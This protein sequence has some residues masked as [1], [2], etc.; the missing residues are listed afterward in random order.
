MKNNEPVAEEKE[1]IIHLLKVLSQ[2]ND[3][4]HAIDDNNNFRQEIAHFEETFKTVRWKTR[5]FLT[6]FG[7]C[8]TD[9]YMAYCIELSEER[10]PVPYLHFLEKL[11]VQLSPMLKR[12]SQAHD[13][14]EHT[15]AHNKD[16]IALSHRKSP[17][18]RGEN[19]RCCICYQ[20][21]TYH[22]EQ[23]SSNGQ[24]CA[25]HNPSSSKAHLYAWN[26]T[27]SI[28]NLSPLPSN[29]SFQQTF[30]KP[31]VRWTNILWRNLNQDNLNQFS[32]NMIYQ[33]FFVCRWVVKNQ[34]T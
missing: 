1:E 32:L 14:N 28:L 12:S 4:C 23:C 17:E 6:I 7:I 16:H 15:L 22:C 24:I 13:E 34:L 31:M 21:T 19:V 29:H 25:V 10:N 3:N 5:F 20:T 30:K 11:A 2:Y 33:F 18:D 8:C 9:A 27:R 26:C